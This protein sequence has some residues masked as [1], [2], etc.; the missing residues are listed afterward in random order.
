[1]THS[2]SYQKYAIDFDLSVGDTV[3]NVDD[4]YVVGL[5]EG[6]KTF[7]LSKKWRAADY[8]NYLTIYHPNSGLYTQ[9]VHLDFEG[10]LV[11]L[12]DFVSRGQVIGISGR[13]GF[14]TTPHLHFNVLKPSED[15]SLISTPIEFEDGTN[16]ESLKKKD[17]VSH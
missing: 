1:F 7:G 11:K 14:T 9:Y 6:Y 8:S 13:T 2:G 3:C 15:G 4:G 12:G 17:V 5:K 16:G 10:V